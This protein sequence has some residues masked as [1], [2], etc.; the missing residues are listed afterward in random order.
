MLD[1]RTISCCSSTKD[2]TFFPKMVDSAFFANLLFSIKYLKAWSY[3]GLAYCMLQN[4]VET[5]AK[6]LHIYSGYSGSNLSIFNLYALF[7][8]GLSIIF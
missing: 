5:S 8:N 2:F 6:L 7:I 4:Y 1:S 3:S